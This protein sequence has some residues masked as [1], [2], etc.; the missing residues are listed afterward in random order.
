MKKKRQH[1]TTNIKPFHC[2]LQFEKGNFILCFYGNIGDDYTR[3]HYFRVHLERWWLRFL[4]SL[5]WKV[6]K[7]DQESINSD[8]AALKGE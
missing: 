8:I 3:R 7:R 5:L 2:E 1:R 6:I 4:V